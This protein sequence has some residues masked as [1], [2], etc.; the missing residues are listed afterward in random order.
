MWI[1][2]SYIVLV[3]ESLE[4]MELVLKDAL[5]QVSAEANVESARK[6]IHD[7]DAVVSTIARHA[8]NLDSKR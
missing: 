4:V 8:R 3:G 6:T 5:M 7:V 1:A 2:P